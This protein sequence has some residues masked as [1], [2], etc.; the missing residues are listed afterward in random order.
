MIAVS[1][2]YMGLSVSHQDYWIAKYNV[3][4]AMDHI[5][6][7]DR[8]YL[9]QL[10]ADAAPIIIPLDF[11]N[12]DEEADMENYY[13]QD[14]DLYLADVKIAG[15]E[16]GIRTFNLSKWIAYCGVIK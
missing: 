13:L 9:Y 16:M 15:D 7:A 10:S 12:T 8:N 14:K 5:T 4:A 3:T 1:V 2:S 6:K 11:K